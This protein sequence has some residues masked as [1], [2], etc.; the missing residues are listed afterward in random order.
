[1]NDL[2]DDTMLSSLSFVSG[3]LKLQE[4]EEGFDRL[5]SSPIEEGGVKLVI[6]YDFAGCGVAFLI[7]SK[8][9]PCYEVFL[10]EGGHVEF[11]ARS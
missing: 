1:M 10:S 6:N 5:N 8:F 4:K 11:T 7:K 3:L 2:Y 9:S